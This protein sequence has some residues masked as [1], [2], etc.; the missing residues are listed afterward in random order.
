MKKT[1]RLCAIMMDTLGREVCCLCACQ[2]F[3]S[4]YFCQAVFAKLV[5][6]QLWPMRGVLCVYL[7][8]QSLAQALI[9]LKITGS[10]MCFACCSG[11][12]QAAVQYCHN[13]VGACST[14]P[15]LAGC[16]A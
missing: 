10:V 14:A 16:G 7:L 12:H 11:W 3:S 4:F 13:P 6:Q 2:N 15:S 9:L 5:G 1:R 8:G